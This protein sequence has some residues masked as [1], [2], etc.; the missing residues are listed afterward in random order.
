VRVHSTGGDEVEQL[1]TSLVDVPA[2]L[3]LTSDTADSYVLAPLLRYLRLVYLDRSRGRDLVARYVADL[4]NLVAR[5]VAPKNCI[6]AR[7]LTDLAPS[8]SD[9]DDSTSTRG[10][11]LRRNRHTRKTSLDGLSAVSDRL[12]ATPQGRGGETLGWVRPPTSMALSSGGHTVMMS[13]DDHAAILAWRVHFVLEDVMPT[14]LSIM[15]HCASPTRRHRGVLDKVRQ[16]AVTLLRH[17]RSRSVACPPDHR[18]MY[19]RTLHLCISTATEILG[20]SHSTT[21]AAAPQ[22]GDLWSSRLTPR[23]LP[24]TTVTATNSGDEDDVGAAGLEGD[25]NL[26]VLFENACFAVVRTE[27]SKSAGEAPRVATTL[28]DAVELAQQAGLTPTPVQGRASAGIPRDG[29]STGAAQG[30]RDKL[31]QLRRCVACSSWARCGCRRQQ[32]GL[33]RKATPKRLGGV[34][35]SVLRQSLEFVDMLMLK[36]GTRGPSPLL[37]RALKEVQRHD[38]LMVLRR[39]LNGSQMQSGVGA[40]GDDDSGEGSPPQAS[41]LCA[42]DLA[43]T[44]PDAVITLT[45]HDLD[46]IVQVSSTACETAFG[47][48]QSGQPASVPQLALMHRCIRVRFFVFCFVFL[49]LHVGDGSIVVCACWFVI[50]GSFM[51]CCIEAWCRGSSFLVCPFVCVA[52]RAM[53]FVAVLCVCVSV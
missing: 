24:P 23:S 19:A 32:R 3:N 26:A 5:L 22:T 16:A 20:V 35:D 12:G 15:L 2:I 47:I 34:R 44:P 17:L 29:E 51:L 10:I 45:V 36:H 18:R 38:H 13:S 46:S 40:C 53:W 11:R 50:V 6:V 1:L 28:H 7:V 52:F 49:V 21:M 41:S 37:L 27:Q 9:H 8:V 25:S 48:I 30:V 33:Q 4:W 31:S 43:R 39:E 42:V 14:I